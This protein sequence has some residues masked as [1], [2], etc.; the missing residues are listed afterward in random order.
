MSVTPSPRSLAAP[1]A[2]TGRAVGG[3]DGRRLVGEA[4]VVER[5]EEPVAAA[6]AGEHAAR[7]VAAVGRGREP[8]QQQPRAR[9]T[10]ARK[11]TRPVALA[12]IAERRRGGGSLAMRD[13]SPAAPAAHDP[14]VETLER[15]RA[16]QGGRIV[17]R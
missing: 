1:W 9:V 6:I 3:V 17:P 15:R 8:D 13:E 14:R 11:R 7:A 12:P 10:E 16:L 4:C 5:L 2:K